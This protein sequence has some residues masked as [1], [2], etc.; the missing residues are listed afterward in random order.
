MTWLWARCWWEIAVAAMALRTPWRW[1][2]LNPPLA[3]RRL[4][5]PDAER[6]WRTLWSASL[7]R[8]KPATCLEYAAALHRLLKRRGIECRLRIGVRAPEESVAAHAWVELPDGT[9]LEASTDGR[10]YAPLERPLQP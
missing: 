6:I 10:E 4:A 9:R 5:S 8:H 3:P 7:R 1:R 2:Y